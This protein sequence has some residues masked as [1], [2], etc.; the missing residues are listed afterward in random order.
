MTKFISDWQVGASVAVKPG[1]KD[2]DTGDD[3][4]GWQGRITE[5]SQDKDGTATICFAWDSLSLKA[6]PPNRSNTP[7]AKGWIGR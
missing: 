5:F 6:C 1:V 4:G 7:S 2:P 3:I